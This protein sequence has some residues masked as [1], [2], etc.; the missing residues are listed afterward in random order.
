VDSFFLRNVHGFVPFQRK[1]NMI[2]LVP[3]APTHSLSTGMANFRISMK[4]L[5]SKQTLSSYSVYNG[6][7]ADYDH[8]LQKNKSANIGQGTEPGSLYDL[9]LGYFS[10]IVLHVLIHFEAVKEIYRESKTYLIPPTRSKN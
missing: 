5:Q 2:S 8:V 10:T 9:Q 3:N 1:G 4:I 7:E 6:I